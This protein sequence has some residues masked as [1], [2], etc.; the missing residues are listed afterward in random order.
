MDIDSPS[1]K[2]EVAN[3]ALDRSVAHEVEN[4]DSSEPAPSPDGKRAIDNVSTTPPVV[5]KAEDETN[6]QPSFGNDSITSPVFIKSEDSPVQA[7]GSDRILRLRYSK[8]GNA[9]ISSPATV[10][11]EGTSNKT[12]GSDRV[13]RTRHTK[14]PTSH[15]D[16]RQKAHS[17]KS[18]PR[19]K[20]KSNAEDIDSGDELGTL[21][22]VSARNTVRQE[23][24]NSTIPKRNAFI[25]HHADLFMPLLPYQNQ[26]KKL[27]TA[28]AKANNS[29]SVEPYRLVQQPKGVMGTMKDYQLS[30][31]SFL[32][33]MYENGMPAILGDEMGLGKTLQTLALFQYLNE[34]HPATGEHRP[35]LVVCPLSV[36]NSWV[37][38]AEKWTP[39]LNVLR[40]HGPASSRGNLK[41]QAM[42][43]AERFG[44]FIRTGKGSGSKSAKLSGLPDVIVTT[45]ETFTAEK[46]W[47]CRAYVW[48]YC[49]LD[50]GHKIKNSA[51]LNS[52]ALQSL[53]TQYRLLLTGTPLQN[54]LREL[55]SLL[56]W[57]LPEV[58]TE[59][60]EDSFA[61]AFDLGKGQVSSDFVVASR[62]LLEVVM[63]RRMK[64]SA[65]VNLG[66]PPKHDV[67]LLIPLSPVQRLWYRR[68]L[69]RADE[70]TFEMLFGDGA[71]QASDTKQPTTTPTAESQRW[72]FLMNLL[73]QLRKCCGHPYNIEGA[74]PEP[75]QFGDHIITA[76]TKLA[77][78]EK[79][80]QKM[81]VADKQKVLIFS[82][83]TTM[84]DWCEDLL[85]LMGWTDARSKSRYIRLDGST[86]AARRNLN[87]KLFND[88][89]SVYKV[90]LISTKAGG[91][92]LNLTAATNVIFL[93][94][95]W[96][97]QTDIQ[98]E[99]RSHRIG[100]TKPV[101]V[102]KLC[103]QGTVEEQM[104]GRINKKRYLSLK[105]TESMQDRYTTRDESQMEQSEETNDDDDMTKLG[106][107][108]LMAMLRQG[109]TALATTEVSAEEVRGWSF[110][111]MIERCKASHEETIANTEEDEE[112]WLAKAERVETAVLDGVK[113]K[114][115][116]EDS[117]QA[118]VDLDRADRRVRKNTTVKVGQYSVS[119]S[120][121][122]CA[123]WEAAPTLAGKDPSLVERKRAKAAPV[124][125]QDHCQICGDET[126]EKVI[127]C[128]GCPR[129]YHLNCLSP[130]WQQRTA[131]MQFYC[132]SHVCADC[133]RTTSQ[134]G[135]MLFRCRDCET[136]YCEDCAQ[137]D[138][139]KL[140]GDNLPEYEKMDYG[141]KASAYYVICQGCV[142]AA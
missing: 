71:A 131:R 32:V 99:A 82:G 80:L 118:T 1:V 22:D 107:S 139:T 129:A 64:S 69:T 130:S 14:P 59:K 7:P 15:A 140:V 96:N 120:S 60:T 11:S 135:G 137:W 93:D 56:H 88:T 122:G 74:Q 8:P 45:Y 40:F 12:P 114:K 87:V 110:E 13:L 92:G 101:T 10:K 44:R 67:L 43:N 27:L 25:A 5:I 141:E 53:N 23:V 48:R 85:A 62:K 17:N 127:D 75:F 108:Q 66:L 89:S 138:K 38:E 97:P 94:S 77:M 105:I 113:Y 86:V 106:T 79:M 134:A 115:A 19:K 33:H 49:V 9:S 50:E 83:F 68:L 78:L 51:S 119:K 24:A 54:N 16:K 132:P 39:N 136:A 81:V 133:E 116:K 26:V 111:T 70:G 102:Y 91:L 58:F 125:H 72:R 42:G 126:F 37:A 128:A 35:Y 124:T 109:A 55:W 28:K 46:T 31:L 76:S 63:L 34:T 30:G 52:T 61:K 36:V 104:M 90:M 84:L 65:G 3:S 18:T 100:Q 117:E 103:T 95:D 123:Q 73:M 142:E 4:S 121:M 57:L 41:Q 21:P 29:R 2:T 112:A 98:A 20:T 6:Q 47:F